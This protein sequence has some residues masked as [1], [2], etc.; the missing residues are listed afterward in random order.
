MNPSDV[1]HLIS[2]EIN[3]ESTYSNIKNWFMLG[4]RISRVSYNV[5]NATRAVMGC[6]DWLLP[7][8]LKVYNEQKQ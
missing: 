7:T 3:V 2:G 6:C 5:V 4:V 8:I 1:K